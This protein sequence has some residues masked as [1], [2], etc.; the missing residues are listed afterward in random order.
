[1]IYFSTFLLSTFITIILIPISRR[2]AIRVH[3]MDN[4]NERKVHLMPMPKSGGIA[5]AF[6]MLVPILLWVPVNHEV[7]AILIGGGI[8]VLRG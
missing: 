3:A 2:L 1:M 4:P 8:V 5:M 7:R 6:G